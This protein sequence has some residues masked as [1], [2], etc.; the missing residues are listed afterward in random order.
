M[1][2]FFIDVG[3]VRPFFGGSGV[4]A[5]LV[6]ALLRKTGYSNVKFLSKKK[7]PSRVNVNKYN[8]SIS[9]FFGISQNSLRLKIGEGLY[10][11]MSCICLKLR[12][13]EW[14]NRASLLLRSALIAVDYRS[15]RERIKGG[16]ELRSRMEGRVWWEGLLMLACFLFACLLSMKE[17]SQV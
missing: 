7:F 12:T 11:V 17:G 9:G 5:K 8:G 6:V 2:H 1:P 4:G 3:R 14:P 16:R 10:H 13:R 15:L